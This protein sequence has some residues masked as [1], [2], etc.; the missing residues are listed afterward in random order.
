M[1][2]RVYTKVVSFA[3]VYVK[4]GTKSDIIMDTQAW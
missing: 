2:T 1:Y 4:V 3:V